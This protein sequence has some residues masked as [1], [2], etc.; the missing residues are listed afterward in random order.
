MSY[1]T[2]GTYTT[3]IGCQDYTLNLTINPLPIVTA[4]DVS[5]CAGNSVSLIGN[6]S[7][8]TFSVANPYIGPT[9]TYTYTYTDG[10]GCTS[11]SAPAN[12]FMSGVP[13]VTGI[14]MSNIG[15][16]SATVNWNGVPGLGWYEVR[17]RLL[18]SASW[19]GGGTQSAPTT[20]KN[21]TG[22]DAA[23][24][25]EIEVRGFCTQNQPG[26]WSAT[27]VFQTG[28]ACPAPQ[29]L[30]ET[31]VTKNSVKL[32][33]SAVPGVA[34]YQIRY[35]T[36]AGPG[37][38][39]SGGTAAASLTSKVISG[40]TANTAYDWQIRAICGQFP[41]SIGTFSIPGDFMTLVSKPGDVEQAVSTL[42]Y[43]VTV[44]PNPTRENLSIELAAQQTQVTVV[45][46]YDLSGRLV[47]QMQTQIEAGIQ[48]IT[49]NISEL[50]SGL[51]TVQVFA[52]DQ[53]VHTSKISKQD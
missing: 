28:A 31:D 20:F 51:Y 35:R 27:S 7:G 18:G 42:D 21:I 4:S 44:Y 12:I 14:S 50:S 40:L 39:V 41:Y 17:Y 22:L 16:N 8:G 47:Q 38:W 13:P 10:N 30:F 33:W 26:P 6:P 36:S 46:L 34:Y 45:K 2:S 3:T 5:A 49:M 52:N 11:T 53:M 48:T 23:S 29:N 32:N 37:A 9:T 1:T 24:I 43:A 19:T 25:Y 15:G